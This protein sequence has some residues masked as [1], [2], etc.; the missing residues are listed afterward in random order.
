MAWATT[1]DVRV[2]LAA[3]G[4]FMRARPAEHTTLLTVAEMVSLR[5]PN[6]YGDEA[7]EFGWWRDGEGIAGTF[8]HTPPYPVLL[9][10]APEEAGAALL[11]ALAGRAP[12]GLNGPVALVQ[13]VAA[14]YPGPVTERRRECLYRLGE[15]IDPPPP[16]G[17]AVVAGAA[18]REQ[19]IE[20]YDAF[21]REIGEVGR[22]WADMVDDRLSHD[23]L[24]VWESERGEPV[25]LAGVSRQIAG[26]VRIAPVYTPPEQR[27][28]GIAAALTAA[29]CRFAR[30]AGAGEIL[31]FAD[32]ANPTSNR[33]YRRIG[34]APLSERLYVEF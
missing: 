24:H 3:A 29:V 18:H 13:A 28:R 22:G 27:G 15:L 5:G 25:A 12:D 20:W 9:G 17:R 21:A 34:F 14:A 1:G 10:P 11:G 19:L 8:L 31:L 33:V 30:Q 2:F 26:M 6:T 7:P 23:G 32:L 4:E 16:P